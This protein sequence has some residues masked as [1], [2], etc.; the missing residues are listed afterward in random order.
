MASGYSE[1]SHIKSLG[2]PILKTLAIFEE[3]FEVFE[4]VT[5]TPDS[6]MAVKTILSLINYVN[7]TDT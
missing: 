5:A 7:E 6:V 1:L 4:V 2:D 3:S